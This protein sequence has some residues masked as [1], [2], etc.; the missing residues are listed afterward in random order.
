MRTV[1]VVIGAD[2]GMQRHAEHQRLLPTVFQRRA[3]AG[4]ARVVDAA[5]LL[6][7]PSF[8]DAHDHSYHVLPK[9]LLEDMPFDVW[10]PHS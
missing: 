5:G 6:M 8:V 1:V 2:M 9:G 4:D 10:A 3:A 7:L